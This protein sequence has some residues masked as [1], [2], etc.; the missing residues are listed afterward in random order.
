[1]KLLV[2]ADLHIGRRCSKLPEAVAD[3]RSPVKMWRK[4]IEFAI[5][6][7][8]DALLIAGDIVDHDRGFYEA[9]NAIEGGIK[10]L[11]SAGIRCIAVA[12]NHDVE[13]MKRLRRTLETDNCNDNATCTDNA[14]SFDCA[15]NSG[16]SGD[17]TAC[18]DD[19]ECI[20]GTDNC[21]D[22]A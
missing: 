12:G 8:V 11:D 13:V 14:G 6:E 3:E 9:L 5:E 17:G 2:T 4:I 21:S 19:D 10:R 1:M 7:Q 16:Y 18:A 22:N 15:C 20:L